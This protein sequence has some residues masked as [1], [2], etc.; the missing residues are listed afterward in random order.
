MR[1]ILFVDDEPR[2]LDGLKRSLRSRR[3]VW[4]MHFAVGAKEGLALLQ[5]SAADVVVSDIRMPGMDGIEFLTLVRDRFPS[6]SRI[7]LS[8]YAEGVSQETATAVAHRFLSKP[9][10]VAELID[11]IEACLGR[12][13]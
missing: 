9:C 2:V 7:F 10:E 8:G 4:T 12:E 1:T 11:A 3:D 5:T 6:A 13:H